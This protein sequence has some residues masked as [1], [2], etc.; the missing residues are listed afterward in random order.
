MADQPAA[1][2]REQGVRTRD[3]ILA[4]AVQV[5]S[6]EGLEGL[7]IGRLASDLGIS[8]SGLFARF[9]SKEDLQ[10]A[11]VQAARD[12]FIAEVTGPAR[13][14]EPGL[15][16]LRKLV[17]LFLSYSRRRIFPGGCFF[18]NA[19]AEFDGRPGPVRD[20]LA[21][22]VSALITFLERTIRAA[23]DNGELQPDTD[24][25]VLAFEIYSILNGANA[26]SVLFNDKGVYR[27]A[28][29]VVLDRL[30]AMGGALT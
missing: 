25:R 12:I 21:N 20:A 19:V 8:K 28:R 23:I 27:M 16:R 3:T 1:A 2:R 24:P 14:L 10:L 30:A 4:H 17:D 22:E 9:G 29:R 11:T 18:A 5:A 15:A 6:V 13:K 7:S 26:R